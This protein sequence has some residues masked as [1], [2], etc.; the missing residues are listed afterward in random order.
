MGPLS[1]GGGGLGDVMKPKLYNSLTPGIRNPLICTTHDDD[2]ESAV[3][4][5][6]FYKLGMIL[7]SIG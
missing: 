6:N 1:V 7:E 3:G 4:Y 2:K 5:A